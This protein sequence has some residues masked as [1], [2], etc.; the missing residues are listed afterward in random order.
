MMDSGGKSPDPPDEL[1]PEGLALNGDT[2]EDSQNSITLQNTLQPL[3]DTQPETSALKNDS[4]ENHGPISVPLLSRPKE[5]SL[6]HFDISF[7]YGQPTKITPG[8][9]SRPKFP[10]TRNPITESF[11]NDGSSTAPTPVHSDKKIDSKSGNAEAVFVPVHQK[12]SLDLEQQQLPQAG[13]SPALPVSPQEQPLV[14]SSQHQANDKTPIQP[15]LARA[16]TKKPPFEDYQP[17]YLPL[18]HGNKLYIPV[19]IPKI[20]P[21]SQAT[22]LQSDKPQAAVVKENYPQQRMYQ[23]SVQIAKQ[24][25]R[26]SFQNDTSFSSSHPPRQVSALASP[27]SGMM[28]RP[29]RGSQRRSSKFN[30][31]SARPQS[32]SVVGS[33]TKRKRASHDRLVIS[34]SSATKQHPSLEQAETP[35]LQRRRWSP[36]DQLKQQLVH[37]L[38]THI[39]DVAGCINDKFIDITAEMDKQFQ[40]ITD[41][42]YTVKQQRDEVAWYRDQTQDKDSV[43]QD[44]K[45]GKDHLA[46]KLQETEQELQERSTKYSRL[47]EKCRGYKDYLNK[48]IAEQQELYKATKAKCDGAII[49]M[50]A[51]E[52]KRKILQE[53]ERKN[54]EAAHEHLNQVVKTTIAAHK[55]HNG[56][57]NNKI[58]SLN[59]KIQERDADILRERETAG[60]LLQQNASI[61][62]IQ[63]TLQNFGTQIEGI[64]SKVNEIASDKN[65]QNH[66]KGGEMDAKIDQIVDQLRSLDERVYSKDAVSKELQELISKAVSSL[67]GTLE[68]VLDSQLETKASLQS[69]SSG[70]CEYIDQ[71]WAALQD[72]EDV[73]EESVGQRQ[74]ENERH[75]NML[76]QRL[77][78]K[79]QECTNQSQLLFYSEATVRE[80]QSTID[81]LQAEISEMEQNQANSSVQIELMECLREEQAKLKQ[82]SAGKAAQV[83]ELQ[84]QLQESKLAAETEGKKHQMATEELQ[85]LI[86]QNNSEA[87]AAQVQAVETAQRDAFLKMN[88]VKADIEERLSQA[89]EERATLRKELYEA[90]Q[91]ISTVENEF[92][93]SSE[94]SNHLEKELEASEIKK[95]K[96]RE[97]MDQKMKEHHKDREHQLKLIED[98]QS[99]L[100]NA[101]KKFSNLAENAQAYDKAAKRVLNG[102]VQWT[103]DYVEVRQIAS[104]LSKNKEGV[105]SEEIDPR[106]KPLIQLQL[107]QKA[108]VQYCQSQKQ[109][110]EMLSGGDAE[111]QA[112][113]PTAASLPLAPKATMDRILD[114]IRR[115][116]IRSPSSNSPSPRPPSVQTEQ[117]RRRTADPPKSIMKYA[118]KFQQQQDEDDSIPELP[119][120]RYSI[121]SDS[122]DA[123]Q[124]G[125][126][127]ESIERKM[128]SRN[129]ILN[130][131]PYNR[132]VAGS[133]AR[134]DLST[135]GKRSPQHKK[136]DGDGATEREST[137]KEDSKRKGR[138]AQETDTSRKRAKSTAAGK[139][140]HVSIPHTSPPE[141]DAGCGSDFEHVPHAP[142]K[143]G[144]RSLMGDEQPSSPIRS[145]QLP[146]GSSQRRT[147]SVTSGGVRGGIQRR[148]VEGKMSV[149]RKSSLNG[150]QDPLALFH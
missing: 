41:L 25:P 111:D 137:P 118:S 40:I 42:K 133:H 83:T 78:S 130:R 125:K 88:Q 71:L 3:P 87:Q 92:S 94:K 98:L 96:S 38:N 142:R 108:V 14:Q 18:D 45:E 15:D 61:T 13:T 36:Q 150:S 143:T 30:T 53:R 26:T 127:K 62:S 37:K 86:D 5:P 11:M 63:D 58:E 19:T 114:R 117:E 48:A 95:A 112:R 47:E 44:L 77:Q 126:S 6:S 134:F 21:R 55:Q 1:A 99:Q 84:T 22:A 104:E 39:G 72:R 148:P 80:R 113:I 120:L 136:L 59:Q 144:H 73:L 138:V 91:R 123:Q 20:S 51:E 69:M 102:L 29:L 57:L 97:E 33:N 135:T 28:N 131:S 49:Q 46:L 70:L 110:A 107:L 116:I 101:N 43:I 129:V 109:A 76:H 60:A 105:L 52:S 103:Q 100:T 10:K 124:Q 149:I 90:K 115:V 27:S 2:G 132:L 75:I 93:S 128:V 81:R 106:F 82:D 16:I 64:V 24:T 146:Q 4:P 141:T 31:P 140:L 7:T 35:S 147:V 79:E 65:P 66:L 34:S 121:R 8:Q 74:A 67:L 54:A 12:R 139:K 32:V 85:K 9:F 119:V 89:L 23:S 122:T 17:M 56:E 145:T 68:P 50:Q